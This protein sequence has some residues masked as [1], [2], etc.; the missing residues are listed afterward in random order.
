M[1]KGGSEVYMAS[2][3]LSFMKL[4]ALQHEFYNLVKQLEKFHL[5][6]LPSELKA[7]KSTNPQLAEKYIKQFE[8][9]KR[10]FQSWYKPKYFENIKRLSQQAIKNPTPDIMETVKINYDMLKPHGTYLKML[11][12]LTR[13]KRGVSL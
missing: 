11:G 9:G 1:A 5:K 12:S 3:V 4:A 7:L 2:Y 13:S 10:F 6:G 8:K